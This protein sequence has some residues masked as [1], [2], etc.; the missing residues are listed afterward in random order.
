MT[1]RVSQPFIYE[2]NTMETVNF[3]PLAQQV[4]ELV[5]KAVVP[6]LAF[7]ALKFLRAQGK[8]IEAS[9]GSENWNLAVGMARGA[10]QAAEQL[11]ARKLIADKKS[12][13]IKWLSNALEARGVFLDEE[14][15]STLIEAMV[16][17]EINRYKAGHP[18]SITR[19][20]S[21]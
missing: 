4:L 7:Y 19:P 10:V 14:T 1:S 2:R 9:I 16:F 8:S 11:G 21:A 17:N 3:W 20:T 6:V 18:A 15:L 5:I 12:Y 13:A